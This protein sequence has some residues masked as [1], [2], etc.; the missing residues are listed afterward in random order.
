MKILELTA[1]ILKN[2]AVIAVV[3]FT[4]WHTTSAWSLL[5]L[6]FLSVWKPDP[7]PPE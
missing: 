1:Y 2:L 5:G 6:V 3:T 7:E 4:V